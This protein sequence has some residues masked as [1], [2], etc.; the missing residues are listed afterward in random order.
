[1]SSAARIEELQKKF[2][3]N[4]RRYFAPL[5]NE[6]R[7]AGDLDAAIA[8]CR[9]HLPQQPGHMSGHIVYGQALFESG[10]LDESRTVF[11]TALGLDPENLIALRHMGD[12]A[13][14]H[15]D[16]GAARQWYMRVLETDPRNEEIQTLVAGLGD[17]QGSPAPIAF[18]DAAAIRREISAA[19]PLYAGIDRLT[20]EG[21]NRADR[22]HRL[23]ASTLELREVPPA[24][25]HAGDRVGELPPDPQDHLLV[26]PGPDLVEQGVGLVPA[27]GQ[28]QDLGGAAGTEHV[29]MLARGVHGRD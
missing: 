23:L 14:R 11:E 28:D 8:I 12:I 10:E 3:E 25:A 21:D 27:F 7:K 29:V 4:P 24:A 6:C 1:M 17:Q 16:L 2:D 26:D 15:G 13:A 5:A 18:D 19:I 9:T 22:L 20:R